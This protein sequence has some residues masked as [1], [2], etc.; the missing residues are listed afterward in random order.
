M[1]AMHC[2]V[3]L[4]TCEIDLNGLIYRGFSLAILARRYRTQISLRVF[5]SGLYFISDFM[6]EYLPESTNGPN[7]IRALRSSTNLPGGVLQQQKAK[8]SFFQV[9][10]LCGL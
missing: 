4:V 6:A 9:S 8:P 7:P 3:Q 2:N 10:C 5:N 1:S